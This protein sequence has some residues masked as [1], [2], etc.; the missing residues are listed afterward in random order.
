[1]F[2]HNA[3]ER[4][5]VLRRF[6]RRKKG[7]PRLPAG[8]R[9]YAIGDVHGRADLLERVF[10]RIDAHQTANPALRPV[11]ILLGDYVD[12]GPASKEV[13]D[14]LIARMETQ[15]TVYLKGNHETYLLRFLRQPSV[16]R[17][18]TMIGGRETLMSYGL[19]PPIAADAKVE[20]E[21]SS[22]LKAVFP[23]SHQHLLGHLPISFTCGEYFFVH[24]GVKP[25]VPL[26][27]QRE[28]DLLWIRDEFLLHEENF[29]KI[30]VHGHTPV[31]ELD[32]RH[33]RINIDTGAYATGRLTCLIMEHDNVEP[34]E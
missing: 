34:L 21:L 8:L 10:G 5:L 16:L 20:K 28:E 30:V 24:A 15:E 23:K 32:I 9:L 1:V 18:W 22:A 33:N 27:K 3:K 12:R 13:L 29:G 17:D 19:K 26:A 4:D 11:A 2:A 31:P 14:L 25:G 6:T 7:G